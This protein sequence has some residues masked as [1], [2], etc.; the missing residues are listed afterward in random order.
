MYIGC[1]KIMAISCIALLFGCSSQK[2]I[3][4][5]T[6]FITNLSK[7]SEKFVIEFNE[8]DN[9]GMIVCKECYWKPE[10]SSMYIG[11]KIEFITHTQ[12]QSSMFG[13]TKDVC[14]GNKYDYRAFNVKLIR[15]FGSSETKSNQ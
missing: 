8:N 7:C 10:L 2:A 11:D 6:G 13:A 4:T 9:I 15:S 3:F 12:I 1:F 14:I 5:H